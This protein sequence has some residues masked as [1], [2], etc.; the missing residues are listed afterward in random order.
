MSPNER[1]LAYLIC[2]EIEK[3]KTSSK[4]KLLCQPYS[5]N[6]KLFEKTRLYNSIRT[7]KNGSKDN[8][9]ID[10]HV[11]ENISNSE[12][13]KISTGGFARINP[14]LNPSIVWWSKREFPGS[15]IYIRLNHHEFFSELPPQLLN[16]EVMVPANPKW[17]RKLKIHRNRKEGASYFIEE[18]ESPNQSF[19]KYW[20]YHVKKIRCLQIS[21]NRNNNGNLSM[22]FEELSEYYID[23]GVLMGK[24]IHLDTDAAYDT[25][26]SEAS[27]NHL[28]L[29]I[30]FY[31]NGKIKERFSQDLSKGKVVGASYRTHILRIENIPFDSV[32]QY[33]LMFFD[34]LYLKVEWLSDQFRD[35]DG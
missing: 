19:Q 9:L 22:M 30:Q 28:D 14:F 23:S 33:L 20:D 6:Q 2:M 12:V 16:E 4:L 29:A 11:V 13:V 25:S 34:S 32:L 15:N 27:L 24:C 17:W 26:S 5:E 1:I 21:A 7:K 35:K 31:E 10:L 18:P 3:I 8:E